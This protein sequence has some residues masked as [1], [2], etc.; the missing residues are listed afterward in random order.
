MSARTPLTVEV[1]EYLRDRRHLGFSLAR[2]GTQLVAFARF[3]EAHGYDGHLTEGLAMAWAQHGQPHRLTAARRLDVVRRFSKY[4]VQFDPQTEIPATGLFGPSTRRL[5]PHIYETHEIEA[6]LTA[7]AQL[8]CAKGLGGATYA[9]LFGLL[10]ATGLRL[11]EALSL[12]RADVDLAQSVLTLTQTKFNRSRLVPLHASTTSALT[13][14]AGVRDRAIPVPLQTEMFFLS[15]RGTRL[16]CRTVEYTFA[17]LREQLRWK[18]RG[19]HA[20]PRIRDLRH[21][22]ICHRLIAW[23]R[24]GI[25]VDRAI[26]ALSTYVGHA[27]V[28]DTYW[29]I[30]GIPELMRIA[31]QRFEC[32]AKRSDR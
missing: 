9:T 2:E 5:T 8:P 19:H 15:A 12:Q 1:R 4:R 27:Q 10:A 14:Y 17:R 20:A 26:L 25:D 30:T 6:L 18:A 22:F 11:S 7:A 24:E 31:A 13:H 29:Y 32:F 16:G 21:T 23:Y 3:A 28:T